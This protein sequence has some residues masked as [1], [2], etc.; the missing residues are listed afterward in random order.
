[1]PRPSISAAARRRARRCCSRAGPWF[2]FIRSRRR[3]KLLSPASLWSRAVSRRRDVASGS[4]QREVSLR[5]MQIGTLTNWSALQQ[6]AALLQS[7]RRDC[8]GLV[9]V[10]TLVPAPFE[11]CIRHNTTCLTLHMNPIAFCSPDF[12][13]LDCLLTKSTISLSA[14]HLCNHLWSRTHN[15]CLPQA[16]SAARRIYSPLSRL[17]WLTWQ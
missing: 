3:L 1:M 5:S 12:R 17:T 10:D 4:Y 11:R 8:F 7:F 14:A 9:C 15:L 16:Y 2:S 6:R 13:R